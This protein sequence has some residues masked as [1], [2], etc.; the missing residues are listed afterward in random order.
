MWKTPKKNSFIITHII[1]ISDN[2]LWI[3]IFLTNLTCYHLWLG[4][5]NC[6]R[7]FRNN[8]HNLTLQQ[9]VY[10]L[11]DTL[12]S[13]TF[14]YSYASSTFRCATAHKKK[15]FSFFP[16][17]F[18]PNENHLLRVTFVTFFL[19]LLSFS[20]VVSSRHTHVSGFGEVH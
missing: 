19:L 5:I 13:L 16:T 1:I 4:F 15:L 10:N 8:F 20:H 17:I 2:W 6:C 12:Q 9:L 14:L 11:L 7:C 18:T 3:K